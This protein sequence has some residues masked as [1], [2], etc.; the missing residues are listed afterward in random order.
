LRDVTLPRI[1]F[2]CTRQHSYTIRSYLQWNAALPFEIEIH[3]YDQLRA[4][5]EAGACIFA[6]LE[7]LAP[8]GIERARRFWSRLKG[9]DPSRRLL[10][11]PVRCM[12][13]YEMLRYLRER[14][15]NLFDACRV[16]E[17][18]SGLRFPVF[19]RN[20][21]DHR[22]ART[23]L[24]NTPQELAAAL[25]AIG[26][27]VQRDLTLMVEFLDTADGDGVYRK[28][29]A[30]NVAGEIFPVHIQFSRHWMVKAADLVTEATVAEELAFMETFPH[31][32]HLRRVFEAAAIDYG[33]IDYS[34]FGGKPQVWE[35]NTNPQVLAATGS[36]PLRSP[37]RRRYLERL[38]MALARVADG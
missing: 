11:H 6:D 37:V 4:I 38:T 16:S 29:S 12:R 7:R 13:R 22:G 26:P 35:I 19:L 27:R 28:Y 1:N 34:L 23:R 30:F 24:L 17:H 9:L 20:E 3:C 2:Y 25:T 32:A 5:P 8:G 15:D 18:R 14:G 36:N 10:N 33:R 21:S 31:E